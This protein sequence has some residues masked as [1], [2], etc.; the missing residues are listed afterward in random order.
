MASH[1][2]SGDTKLLELL[3]RASYYKN[4]SL[5]LNKAIE[6]RYKPR[7]KLPKNHEEIMHDYNILKIQI[8][9]RLKKLDK[10]YIDSDP[11]KVH[12]IKENPRIIDCKL[13]FL[14]R[15]VLYVNE[16]DDN[17]D[18]LIRFIKA[19]SKIT[20]GSK[21]LNS[22]GTL[23]RFTPLMIAS[24]LGKDKIIE[25]LIM[26]GA[27]RNNCGIIFIPKIGLCYPNAVEL[28]KNY[29]S[30]PSPKII[31]GLL[32]GVVSKKDKPQKNPNTSCQSGTN[33]PS[34]NNN[35]NKNNN[36]SDDDDDLVNDKN[37]KENNDEFKSCIDEKFDKYVE[38]LKNSLNSNNDDNKSN[39]IDTFINEFLDEIGELFD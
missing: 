22:N 20:L 29:N 3:K 35:N 27:R 12:I 26:C 11:H 19:L 13:T 33:A 34:K 28:Y 16:Y 39:D 14:H 10:S 4:R 1:S 21:L 2:K 23:C 25:T 18:L 8:I 36:D 30:N 32:V 24:V 31:A 15:A 5:N 7:K 9:K 6:T 17:D 37:N 38:S